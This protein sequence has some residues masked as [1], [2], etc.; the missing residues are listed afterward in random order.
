MKTLKNSLIITALF[1]IFSTSLLAADHE[2]DKIK[3][4]KKEALTMAKKAE[5]MSAFKKVEMQLIQDYLKN[6]FHQEESEAAMIKVFDQNDSL[7]FEGE[8]NT[9]EARLMMLKSN[10]LATVEGTDYYLFTK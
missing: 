4:S 3:E 8:K 6:E 1:T 7:I 2:I 5:M 10:K 9:S